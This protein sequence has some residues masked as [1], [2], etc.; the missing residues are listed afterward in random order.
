MIF[1]EGGGERKRKEEKYRKE[2]EYYRKRQGNGDRKRMKKRLINRERVNS[3]SIA[4]ETERWRRKGRIII[5]VSNLRN[6]EL[7]SEI[8]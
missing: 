4:P 8:Q 6:E 3:R 2:K 7:Y 5:N 1:I